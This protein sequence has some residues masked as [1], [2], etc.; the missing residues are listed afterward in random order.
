M[1]PG[2]GSEFSSRCR[3]CG[4]NKTVEAKFWPWLSVKMP[5]GAPGKEKELRYDAIVPES[6]PLS[7]HARLK[8]RENMLS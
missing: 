4:T 5:R 6:V 3:E 2:G 7:E 8:I 1:S